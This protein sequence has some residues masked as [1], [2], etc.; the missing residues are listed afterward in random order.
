MFPKPKKTL[1]D[2]RFDVGTTEHNAT[3]QLLV[4]SKTESERY[5]QHW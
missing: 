3:E 2:E 1:R 4:T 5:F